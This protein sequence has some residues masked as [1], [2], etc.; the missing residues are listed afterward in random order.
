[1]FLHPSTITWFGWGGSLTKVKL[2]TNDVRA[3]LVLALTLHRGIR[4]VVSTDW[5]FNIALASLN[6]I[7]TRAQPGYCQRLEVTF[8]RAKALW[9]GGAAVLTPYKAPSSH[10]RS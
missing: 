8:T 4:A 10:R 2:V 3:S 6:D 9:L 7:S 1:M 5:V